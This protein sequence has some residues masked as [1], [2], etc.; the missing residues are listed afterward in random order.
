MTC[1]CSIALR[2]K[3]CNLY[4]HTAALDACVLSSKLDT[5]AVDLAT[6]IR[7][8]ES[9]QSEGIK[10]DE[11]FMEVLMT[12][13]GKN[14][15]LDHA[16]ALLDD[17]AAYNMPLSSTTVSVL[18]SSCL[19]ASDL[20]RA[21]QTY[22]RFKDK[23]GILPNIRCIDL[24]IN[25]LGERRD[26]DGAITMVCDLIA[27]GLVPSTTTFAAILQAC[28]YAGAHELA[29]EVLKVMRQRG[30]RVDRVLAMTLF[31][32]CYNKIRLL[33]APASGY[34]LAHLSTAD[35][36]PAS[37]S[38]PVPEERTAALLHALTGR[39][40]EAPKNDGSG[41][42][43]MWRDRAHQV[44]CSMIADGFT[45]DLVLLERL[46][47]VMRKANADRAATTRANAQRKLTISAGG[48]PPPE[49]ESKARSAADTVPDTIFSAAQLDRK[50]DP[51]VYVYVEDAIL[52]NVL[53]PM[54]L[55]TDNTFDLRG[56]PPAVAE[57]YVLTL[58]NQV[59]R[60]CGEARKRFQHTI[61]LLTP[62]FDRAL[63]NV[64]SMH[65][66]RFLS[67]KERVKLKNAPKPLGGVSLDDVDNLLAPVADFEVVR[68][69]GCHNQ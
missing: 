9:V 47:G 55:D 43:R 23:D 11:R 8:Y 50:F 41:N 44:H 10:L 52:R 13:F 56:L 62:R 37:I 49:Y 54:N 60:R 67:T 4:V 42:V 26:L 7:I 12:A 61:T 58:F 18:V 40:T 66:L 3:M 65:E 16:F 48:I 46:F 38:L 30:I 63:V 69:A 45:E 29:F 28:Q 51:R 36:I 25:A 17:M 35:E 22:A 5:R 32:V 59:Y 14:G 20:P 2:S 19:S 39:T 24:L 31:R 1:V 15:A 27:A 21:M 6:A 57:A 68:S 64:P 33:W 53:P 34:P